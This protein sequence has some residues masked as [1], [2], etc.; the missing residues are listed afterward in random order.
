MRYVAGLAVHGW[1]TASQGLDPPQPVMQL[2]FGR[3]CNSHGTRSAC[4]IAMLQRGM[5]IGQPASDS[6]PYTF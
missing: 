2:A 6:A 4:A 3:W 5:R 1:D